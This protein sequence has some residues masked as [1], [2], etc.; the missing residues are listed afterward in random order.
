MV[1]DQ[2]LGELQLLLQ[3]APTGGQRGGLG[4]QL[5]IQDLPLLQVTLGIAMGLNA[6]YR[7]VEGGDIGQGRER[8]GQGQAREQK[9]LP[10]QPEVT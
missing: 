1:V 7:V 4:Q 2:L 9:E 3:Q 5:L 6:L 10:L 8:Y